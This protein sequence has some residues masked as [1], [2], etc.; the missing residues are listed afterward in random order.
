VDNG[1]KLE[2]SDKQFASFI[3]KHEAIDVLV[4]GKRDTDVVVDEWMRFLDSRDNGKVPTESIMNVG[5][6]EAFN[7]FG[8]D[9]I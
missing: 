9:K 6:W 7:E 5:V 3:A 1:D 8:S 2:V 4:P